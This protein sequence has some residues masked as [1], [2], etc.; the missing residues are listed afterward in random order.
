MKRPTNIF[1]SVLLWL[2]I[3]FT[4]ACGQDNSTNHRGNEEI[5]SPGPT[6]EDPQS[7][8]NIPDQA[9]NEP[10]DSSDEASEDNAEETDEPEIVYD[11]AVA[12]PYQVMSYESGLDS[13]AYQSAAVFYPTDPEGNLFSG[14]FPA[15][16]LS[17]GFTNTKEQMFWLADRMA[18][19]GFVVQVFTPTNNQSLD[20][21]IWQTG[22][23]GS[24]SMLLAENDNPDSPIFAMVDDQ[25]LGI[26]GF[27]MGGA[28]TILA[29]NNLGDAIAVAAP[30]N[31]FN[32]AAPTMTAATLF[33]TGTADNVARPG[34]ILNTYEALQN[35]PKAFANFNGFGHA[36]TNPGAFEPLVST[37]IVSWYQTQAYGREGYLTYLNGD[38][39]QK[40]LDTNSFA[41]DGYLLEL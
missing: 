34:P 19:H 10:D 21:V 9:D 5:A 25:A 35:S 23:E 17:G 32:P 13:N 2:L 24:I 6:S 29:A 4:A 27:S 41:E 1:T 18:S 3:L 22:H 37:Y 33:V 14:P 40:D 12:G 8:D 38:E 39:N 20:P 30:L 36:M 7:A 16:T 26:M 28:G 31:A 11:P 15:T